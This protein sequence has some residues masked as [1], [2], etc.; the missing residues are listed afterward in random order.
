MGLAPERESQ[1]ICESYNLGRG[2]VPTVFW[3]KR[4]A[5][6]GREFSFKGLSNALNLMGDWCGPTPTPND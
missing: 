4:F 2:V 5:R 3:G 1:R 6:G